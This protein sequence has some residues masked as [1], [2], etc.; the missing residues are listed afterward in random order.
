[1]AL[2]RFSSMEVSR[3]RARSKLGRSSAKQRRSGS[4]KGQHHGKGEHVICESSHVMVEYH[5]KG[6]YDALG[7]IPKNA[8][9][10]AIKTGKMIDPET[11]QLVRYLAKHKQAPLYEFAVVS[12]SSRVCHT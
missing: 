1:M 7:N 9:A 11:Q 12:Y 8:V 10:D 2:C 4:H 5:G 3:S 6:D